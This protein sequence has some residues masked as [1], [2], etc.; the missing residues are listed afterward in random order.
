MTGWP[1][2]P[3]HKVDAVK[4]ELAAS[5]GAVVDGTTL[6]LTYDEPLDRSSTPEEGDFTVA[7]GSQSRTVTGVRVS[8]S[9][10][11]L[12]LNAGAEHLEAGIQVSYT[13][14]MNPIRD[15]PGNEA[16][17]LSREPVTN[18]TPDTTPPEVSSLA[19]TSNPGDLIRSYA[20]GDEI[21]VT[22]TFS[23]TV[24]VEGTP[25]LRLRVGSQDPNGRLPERHGYGGAGVR[26][27]GG[28][29]GRGHRRGEHR[30]GPDLT[31]NGGTIRRRSGQSADA[32]PRRIGSQC[33]A[34]GGRGPAGVSERGGGRGL[35][36]LTYGEALDGGSRPAT[37]DF[38]VEVDGAGRSVSGVSVSG[39]VVTLTLNPAV[40]HGDTGIRVSYTRGGGEPDPGCSGQRRPGA[41]QPVCD[42]HHRSAQHGS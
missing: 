21:E 13:P 29:W 10:V 18:E 1:P 7:G 4:P 2:T 24:E 28:R 8:G 30:G 20:A 40:E 35:L 41:E 25:Q 19:I 31:L 42:Q 3:G 12:T 16:E 11:V 34:Q 6:T 36:T 17:G 37:G 32:D 38:T 39:S 14:G 26:L 33:G 22:V 9:T 23:E 27:R 15:V 5:G